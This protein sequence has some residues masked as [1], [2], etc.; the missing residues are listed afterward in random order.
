MPT[1]PVTYGEMVSDEQFDAMK[2]A[3]DCS[4]GGFVFSKDIYRKVLAQP[5]VAG[6]R[7]YFVVHEGVLTIAI[8]AVDKNLV[9]F[10]CAFEL[11][12]GID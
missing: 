7:T 12:K 4:T 9:D 1:P 5:G 6:I 3:Y 11:S 10:G 8:K 2:R